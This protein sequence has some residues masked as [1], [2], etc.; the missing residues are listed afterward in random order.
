MKLNFGIAGVRRGRTYIHCLRLLPDCQVV[1]VCDTDSERLAEVAQQYDVP[2]SFQDYE[3]MLESGR[4]NA[5]VVCTPQFLHAPQAVAALRRNIHVLSEVSAAVDLTQCC[6]LVDAARAS[7]AIYMMGEN[8]CYQV[9]N[10]LVRRMVEAGLFGEVYFAEAEYTHN[11][12]DLCERTPW[13]LRWQTGINGITYPTHQLGPVV[14][15]MKDTITG[16]ACLGSG[17]HYRDPRGEPYIQEDCILMLGKTKR[18]SLVKIRQDILSERPHIT[19][20]YTLQGT[21]GCYESS[22]RRAES[23]VGHVWLRSRSPN[24]TTWLPLMEFAEEFLPET[25]R[26]TMAEVAEAG[27]GGTDY[28]V[29]RHFVESVQEGRPPEMDLYFALDTT[30]PGIMSQYSIALN[31]APVRVPDFR[32]Y[33]TGSGILP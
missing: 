19:T 16:V 30:V 22:R 33:V 11:I 7:K 24:A 9:P 18:G 3:Q 28:W 2:H 31:G 25:F 8:A 5:V 14:Q 1:A 17:H 12:K 26:R 21:E 10:L 23:D 15:W 6:Q 20:A 13:R 29:T 27:H 32:E 4:I